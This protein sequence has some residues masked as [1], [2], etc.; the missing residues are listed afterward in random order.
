MK[1]QATA[2]SNAAVQ[3]TAEK[4]GTIPRAFI[5]C[6]LDQAIPLEQQQACWERYLCDPVITMETSHSPFMSQPA[7]LAGYLDAI[8]AGI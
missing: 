6:T 1:P 7:E 8:A 5:A 2:I 4:W 3:T